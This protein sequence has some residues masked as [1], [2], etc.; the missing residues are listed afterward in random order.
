MSKLIYTTEEQVYVRCKYV[1]RFLV[2][3]L[4]P[5]LLYK[6]RAP[7]C[8]SSAYILGV[9]GGINGDSSMKKIE[10]ECKRVLSASLCNTF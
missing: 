8:Y 3:A 2:H 4:S 1:C 9:G 6:L 10:G 7:L 5:C